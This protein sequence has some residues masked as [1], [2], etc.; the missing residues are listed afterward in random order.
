[1]NYVRQFM[2]SPT[3]VHIAAVKRI[4]RYLQGTIQ[5]GICYSATAEVSLNAFSDVDYA[6]DLNT[7]RSLTCYEV[8]LGSKPISWQSKKQNSVSRSSTKVDYKTLAHTAA[9]ITWERYILKDLNVFLPH[10]PMIHCDNMYAISLS[11][12]PVFHSRIKHLDTDYH[13]V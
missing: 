5:A 12:N 6:T 9:D 1:M 2:T 4:L 10:P 7:R 8:F 11:A 3:D 13:F